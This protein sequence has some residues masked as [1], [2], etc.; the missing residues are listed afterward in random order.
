MSAMVGCIEVFGIVTKVGFGPKAV[1]VTM[2]GMRIF[3]APAR[4]GP[5]IVK[6]TFE[7]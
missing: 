3:A 7:F 5:S 6:R 1:L 2:G 4:V